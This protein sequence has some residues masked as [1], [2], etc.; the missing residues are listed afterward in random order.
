MARCW[1]TPLR[2]AR[3]QVIL[4]LHED[5]ILCVGPCGCAV[6]SLGIVLHEHNYEDKGEDH[7]NCDEED[8]SDDP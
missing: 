8:A 4:L 7:D 5:V 3:L 1:L 2:S 6:A